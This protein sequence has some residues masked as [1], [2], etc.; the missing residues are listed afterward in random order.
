VVA[1]CLRKSRADR[2][3]SMAEVRT[4]LE[5]VSQ[6]E[7]LSQSQPSIAVLPFANMSGD[8]ENEYF[9]DGLAEEIIN[10]LTRVKG[11]K[12]IARTSSFAFRGKEQDITKIAETLRVK[13]ILEGR[14][15]K[16]GNRVRVTAQLI[17]AADGSHLWSERYDR[18]LTD[19][20][21]IQD[22]IS[23]AI[24]NALQVKLLGS[25]RPTQN[26]EAYQSYLKGMY[27]LHRVT[28]EG[29][30]KAKECFEQA[31]LQDPG[32]A[33]ALAGLAT[34]YRFACYAY[35][36]PVVEVLPLA[37]SAAQ[38]ALALDPT[39]P[40]GH[41][42]LATMAGSL[43]YDWNL[44]Q[45]EFQIAMAS[46]PVPP[47]VRD[48]YAFHFLIPRRRFHEALEQLHRALE[49]DP[50]STTLHFGFALI[51]YETGDFDAA[52][53]HAAF[54]LEIDP[55]F[56]PIHWIIGLIQ[57]H[58]GLLLD[59][60]ASFER[61]LELAP[62]MSAVAGCLAGVYVR[63]GKPGQ[64]EPL[65]RSE[66]PFGLAYYHAIV[67]DADKMFE[68]LETAIAERYYTVTRI[69]AMPLFAHYRSDPRFDA[70]LRKMN[71]A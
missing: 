44:A 66:R 47:L 69:A 45:R 25:R 40:E 17:T 9:S 57:F 43:E 18:E 56:W 58:G 26:I 39:L 1:R 64:A 35:F 50:L 67:G 14:V 24:A 48:E 30:A 7:G 61:A 32:Y 51:L 37:K 13:T 54:A 59:S 60:I 33:L 65:V 49:I 19:L 55:N 46:E 28:P 21:E 11:L 36:N 15:R 71:L 23:R 41:S 52:L 63:V 16:A 42:A 2:F 8:K 22:D 34:Y 4:A 62:W 68:C 38:K 12:V 31:I 3:Q 29:M 10:A 5:R 20:F 53:K 70:L 6:A 27:H